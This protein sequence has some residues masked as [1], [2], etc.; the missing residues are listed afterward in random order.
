MYSG[1][2]TPLKD[3]DW[4]IFHFEGLVGFTQVWEATRKSLRYEER[5]LILGVLWS[6]SYVRTQ[7]RS[8]TFSYHKWQACV[9]FLYVRIPMEEDRDRP[10]WEGLE[11]KQRGK[12][13]KICEVCGAPSLGHNFGAVSCESC[14][15]FF[16]RNAFRLQVV[17]LKSRDMYYNSHSSPLF[18][19]KKGNGQKL[20]LMENFTNQQLWLTITCFPFRC[21]SL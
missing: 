17:C 10:Q 18:N 2:Y 3:L 21:W 12:A 16:R 8:K 1:T 14:K 4:G 5:T 20:S 15:A 9:W 19:T 6:Q 11:G 7:K 13:E